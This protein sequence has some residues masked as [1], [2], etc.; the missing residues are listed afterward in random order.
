LEHNKTNG[1]AVTWND[2]LPYTERGPVGEIPRCP[3]GGVYTIGKVGDEP[4]CSIGGEHSL[5]H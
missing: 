2:I 1:A 3:K 5:P 4:T